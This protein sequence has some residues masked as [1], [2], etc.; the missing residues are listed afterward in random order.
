MFLE[1]L[2]KV[3][4][5]TERLNAAYLTKN[6]FRGKLDDLTF[7]IHHDVVAALHNNAAPPHIFLIP[8]GMHE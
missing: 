5:V 2:D 4:A 8:V 3:M 1:S 6:F 7:F